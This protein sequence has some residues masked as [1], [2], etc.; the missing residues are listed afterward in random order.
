EIAAR[1]DT[2]MNAAARAPVTAPATPAGSTTLPAEDHAATIDGLMAELAEATARIMPAVGA[3]QPSTQPVYGPL[4][5]AQYGT[6]ATVLRL[7]HNRDFHGSAPS[8]SLHTDAY[9]RL[10]QRRSSRTGT[11][12]YYVLGHLLNHNIGGPGNT[13]SNLVP[14]SQGA[15]N[16]RAD[17]MLHGFEKHVKD[18]VD[19]STPAQRKAVNFVVT[20][21]Y[22]AANRSSDALSALEHARTA[23]SDSDKRRW[24]AIRE[25]VQEEATV[26]RNVSLSAHT[27]KTD[28]TRDQQL[29]NGDEVENIPAS[30]TDIEQYGVT[31][32]PNILEAH[33]GEL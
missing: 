16:R 2:A 17:S 29:G 25:V 7:T 32:R 19:A 33:S 1:L 8:R 26:P 4:N 20:A 22:G 24:L 27:L 5:S 13:W 23:T 15:N 14:L 28:G 11:G 6:S 9:T 30:E 21:N 31:P 18:T 10:N 3:D 12:S